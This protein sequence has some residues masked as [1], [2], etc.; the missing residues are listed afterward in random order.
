MPIPP[1][2]P[3]S[4][5]HITSKLSLSHRNEGLKINGSHKKEDTGDISTVK[6][7]LHRYRDGFLFT[8][9]DVLPRPLA[10]VVEIDEGGANEAGRERLMNSLTS[11]PHALQYSV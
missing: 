4:Q 10:P 9:G 5:G 8:P 1:Q 3:H 2:P 7:D 6:T 11:A